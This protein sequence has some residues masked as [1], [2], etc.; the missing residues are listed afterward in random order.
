MTRFST[1]FIYYFCDFE[2]GIFIKIGN[3]QFELGFRSIKSIILFL[4]EICIFNTSAVVVLEVWGIVF[5]VWQKNAMNVRY[6]LKDN[7]I[8]TV[9]YFTLLLDLFAILLSFLNISLV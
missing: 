7:L 5:S 2:Y 1:I 6:K 3:W 4:L 8:K 9:G